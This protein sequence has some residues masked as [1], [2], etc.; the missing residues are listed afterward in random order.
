M[1]LFISSLSFG[2][3]FVRGAS[4]T[5][6]INWKARSLRDKRLLHKYGI[7]EADYG[8]LFK[9]QK[10]KCAICGRPP[11]KI[12]L[13]IDHDHKTGAIRGLLCFR[14]NY[15]LPWFSSDERT[16]AKAAAYIWRSKRANKN[17]RS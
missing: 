9:A 8:K 6:K 13:A 15:G 5:V 7:T 3:L 4:V 10:G 2:S 12:R 14:C 1:L 16:L 17:K 11:K